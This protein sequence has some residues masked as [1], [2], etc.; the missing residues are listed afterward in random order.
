[1]YKYYVT[2]AMVVDAISQEHAEELARQLAPQ[3]GKVF[4]FPIGQPSPFTVTPLALGRGGSKELDGAEVEL[5]LKLSRREA[6]LLF[7]LCSLQ[8]EILQNAE[9]TEGTGEYQ[10]ELAV[11]RKLLDTTA[12]TLGIED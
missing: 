4:V 12:N 3:C 6:A 1:M 2:L 11:L 7:D 10:E 8:H 9:L 5:K